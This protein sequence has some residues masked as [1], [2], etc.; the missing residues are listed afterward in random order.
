[1]KVL[2]VFGTRPEAVKMAP[3]VKALKNDE[4]NFIPKICVTA[5]HRDMLDQVLRIFDIKP[6]YDLNI[7]QGGQTLTQITCRAL[8]GLEGVIEDFRPDLILVQGDTTTVFSGALAA[9]YHQVKIGHVEAGLR[10]GNLYSPYPEEANRMMTGVLTDFHFAPTETS[11]ANLLRE[12][13]NESKIF[14]TG[15]TSIDALNW[16]IDEDFKFDNEL[17]NQI[18]FN[19][20]KVIL[21]TSHRRENIGEPM[22][23]IFTAIKDIVAG[24]DKVEVIYPMHLNPKVREIASEILGNKERV[25][26][27]EPLDYLPFT[28]LMSK[29]YLVVTDSGGVQEEA[30]SL[31]KPVL[32][33]RK[34]TERPEGIEA[35]TAKLVGVDKDTIYNE[36]YKLINNKEEYNRMANAVNPYGD[37]R[38]AEYITKS[39]KK[40]ML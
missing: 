33:V 32:V 35:G 40:K 24:D 12:G 6:D 19:N 11:K 9:F 16:V 1:M 25:H 7:F 17:I 26:L 23:N 21:L 5:Q 31:G 20:K 13:Y 29:C 4:E 18:D 27:I 38:A 28:N 36:L 8:T 22:V 34:E 10:S 30:P 2:V 3:I 37:G 15:N 39:I 14:I